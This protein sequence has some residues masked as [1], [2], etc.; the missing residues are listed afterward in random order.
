MVTV[1]GES[2]PA[3]RHLRAE[4]GIGGVNGAVALRAHDFLAGGFEQN[5][6]GNAD[7]QGPAHLAE[8]NPAASGLVAPGPDKDHRDAGIEE[9]GSEGSGAGADSAGDA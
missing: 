6:A 4:N 9:P 8:T 2:H 7:A 3:V 5:L 1:L